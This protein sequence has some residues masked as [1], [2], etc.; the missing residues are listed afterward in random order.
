M[1]ID[2]S[3]TRQM[4]PLL[5]L[6][7][8]A[9]LGNMVGRF[10]SG[11]KQTKESK[12]IKPI[13][14]QYQVNPFAK[15]QLATAQNAYLDPSMGTRPQLNR[16]LSNAYGNFSGGVDRNSTSGS[17]SLALKAAGLGQTEDQMS[18][19][20]LDFI[21][22]RMGLLQNLNQAYGT[23]IDEGD[24]VYQSILQKY[25]MDVDRKDALRNAGA[26]NKYG[27]VSDLASMAF[28]GGTSGMKFGNPF[29][30]KPNPLMNYSDFQK[31]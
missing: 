13:W 28:T 11:A 27:A 14:Q 4:N 17:Q 19:A 31:D 12:G 23:N 25:G 29:A 7:G 16:N 6:G 10:I 20:N 5:A 26:Q 18:N 8:I 3:P 21:K 2:F 1:R 30:K 9:A 24:K 22:N 15:Q